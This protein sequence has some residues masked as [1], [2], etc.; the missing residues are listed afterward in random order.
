MLGELISLNECVVGE[1]VN[2]CPSICLGQWVPAYMLGSMGASV[3]AWVN[4]CQRI[5]LGQWVPEYMLGSMGARVY[6]QVRLIIR[7][8]TIAGMT[9][10]H[11]KSRQG[12]V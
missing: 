7:I 1:S 6:A 9:M 2:G 3:Y 11:F 8:I 5:C 12:Q 10:V 4:G